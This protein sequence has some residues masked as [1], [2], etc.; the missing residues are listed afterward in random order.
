MTHICGEY[1]VTAAREPGVWPSS[2][3]IS[4]SKKW[5]SSANAQRLLALHT[6]CLTARAAASCEREGL[7]PEDHEIAFRV[8]RRIGLPPATVAEHAARRTSYSRK[9]SRA[10]ADT[11]L[12]QRERDIFLALILPDD[13]PAL[14]RE[15]IAARYG[16]S[17]QRVHAIEASARRKMAVAL[18]GLSSH[19][20]TAPEMPALSAR[21]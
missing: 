10:L 11:V 13:G 4:T 18:N 14:S 16:L 2:P 19:A 5:Q 12:G 15:S 21:A 20:V 7:P 3:N 1:A 9:Q 17:L 8:G 6:V